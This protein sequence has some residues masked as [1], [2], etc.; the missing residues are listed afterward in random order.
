M[1]AEH[2]MSITWA[3]DR[4]MEA[5]DDDI[6]ESG[7]ICDSV[8]TTGAPVFVGRGGDSRGETS[9]QEPREAGVEGEIPKERGM[10]RYLEDP[11]RYDPPPDPQEERDEAWDERQRREDDYCDFRY[12]RE[13]GN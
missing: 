9:P 7:E 11:H 8:V 13:H 3:V 6:S 2:L 12:A 1:N 10:M 4:I 5:S